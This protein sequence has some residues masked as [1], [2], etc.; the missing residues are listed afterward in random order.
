M[1]ADV[2]DQTAAFGRP[3]LSA[4]ATDLMNSTVVWDNH[5]CMPIRADDSFLP[6]LERYRRAGFNV[7][8]INVGY[9]D[10]P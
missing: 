8:S 5:G 4:R 9:A 3:K 7:V 10:T 2:S 1:Q 6:Q